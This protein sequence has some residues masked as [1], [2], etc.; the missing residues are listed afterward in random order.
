MSEE[1]TDCDLGP[2]ICGL[3][4]KDAT[5]VIDLRDECTGEP[6]VATDP[7]VLSD[8]DRGTDGVANGSAKH[9]D[10]TP[11]DGGEVETGLGRDKQPSSEASVASSGWFGGFKSG[12][13]TKWT[14][15]TNS[16]KQP[17]ASTS[18]ETQPPQQ[19]SALRPAK[20]WTSLN[21]LISSKLTKQTNPSQQSTST[22]L[23]TSPEAKSWS[24]SLQSM[25]S[26]L[27]QRG[28][29]LKQS[30]ESRIAQGRSELNKK[31]VSYVSGGE[32]ST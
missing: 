28:D 23:G 30:T 13:Q 11:P 7:H 1:L 18:A 17:S 27:A 10:P 5:Q 31:L 25:K 14:A 4:P 24:A 32:A 12:S 8:T 22:S 29:M 6:V 20:S 2:P 26:S 19:E 9:E 21:Q 16:W 3:Q 15:M